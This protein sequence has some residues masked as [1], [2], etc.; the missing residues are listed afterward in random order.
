MDRRLRSPR[1]R[2]CQGHPQEPAGHTPGFGAFRG[3]ARRAY[4]EGRRLETP[5]ASLAE[6]NSLS[7]AERYRA[8]T[9]RKGTRPEKH[10]N[11]VRLSA[12]R[13]SQEGGNLGPGLLVPDATSCRSLDAEGGCRSALLFHPSPTAMTADLSS[14][15]VATFQLVAFCGGETTI[16]A[17]A[18]GRWRR[19]GAGRVVSAI[20]FRV[21]MERIGVAA[22][23]GDGHARDGDLLG[24][25]RTAKNRRCCEHCRGAHLLSLRSA[26]TYANVQTS[27]WLP[28]RCRRP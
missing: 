22:R 7:G 8:R 12:A 4:S 19:T 28:L 11:P 24:D 27:H 21:E 18:M 5:L 16:I 25:C 3:D 17:P 20:S 9:I 14:R 15:Q 26:V 2:R 1:Y 10:P 13:A 6:S 23:V